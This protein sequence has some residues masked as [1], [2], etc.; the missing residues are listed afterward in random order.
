[1]LNHYSANKSSGGENRWL[2][3]CSR[4]SFSVSSSSS[5]IPH[6]KDFDKDS[7]SSTVDF[8]LQIKR[9]LP[10]IIFCKE[11]A[12]PLE[13]GF[14]FC[15]K[16]LSSSSIAPVSLG[17]MKQSAIILALRLYGCVIALNSTCFT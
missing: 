2:E 15:E 11:Y 6:P 14:V 17:V 9:H 4:K 7:P 1:M 8:S 16:P 13:S 12:I 10:L 3:Q 5:H